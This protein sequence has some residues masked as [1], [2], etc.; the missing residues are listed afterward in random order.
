MHKT[1]QKRFAMNEIES[2]KQK[3]KKKVIENSDEEEKE[4]EEKK[5]LKKTVFKKKKKEAKITFDLAH[6]LND[7]TKKF[8]KIQLNLIQ[9]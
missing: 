5:K 4:K 7:L 3:G 1:K 9:K 6:N 2:H 8:E